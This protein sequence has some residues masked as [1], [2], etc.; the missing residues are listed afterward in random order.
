M[1]LPGASVERLSS[2]GSVEDL[3]FQVTQQFWNV[4]GS[5]TIKDKTGSI[6][7]R[8]PMIFNIYIII[9]LPQNKNILSLPNLR[10]SRRLTTHMGAPYYISN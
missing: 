9:L 4:S 3:L 6:A 8:S 7:Y 10:E 2:S 5:T 1:P